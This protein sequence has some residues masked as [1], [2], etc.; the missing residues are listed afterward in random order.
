MLSLLPSCRVLILRMTFESLQGNEALSHVD[1]N[2][3]VCSNGGLTPGFPLEFQVENGLLLRCSGNV[4]I[5]LQTKQVMDPHLKRGVENRA[6]LELWRETQCS[7][8][9]GMSMSGTYLSCLKG[10]KYPFTFL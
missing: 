10:V 2:F 3:R 6:L 5:P 8:H 7:F 9:V 4:G 1:R